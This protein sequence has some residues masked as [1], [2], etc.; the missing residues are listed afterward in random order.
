MR[1]LAVCAVLLSLANFTTG[2]L[3]AASADSPDSSAAEAPPPAPSKQSSESHFPIGV[4]VKVSTLGIGGEV[5][6]GLSQRSNVRFGFNAFGYGHTF[7]KDGATYK[8]T[9]DLR[10][11]QATYDIFPV[12][13]FH[14]SPGVLL[15][16]GNKVNAKVSVPGGQTFTLS[17][18]TYLS[19]AADPVSGTG[20]LTVYKAAPM[21]L[22]GFG[23]L[24]PRDGHFS[25]TFEIG[26]AYQGPPRVALNLVHERR[27]RSVRGFREQ[28]ACAIK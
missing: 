14:I 12:R 6:V 24:V 13:W 8:G 28:F 17:N 25:A 26:A 9:L 4:G 16:N 18:T 11:A 27:G 15:Y 22:F 2:G 3:A 1:R 5:A 7:D 23:N 10:S 19:D 21:V 20:K